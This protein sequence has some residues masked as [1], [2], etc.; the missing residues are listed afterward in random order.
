MNQLNWPTIKNSHVLAQITLFKIAGIQ[1]IVIC[2]CT[3]ARIPESLLISRLNQQPGDKEN[4]TSRNFCLCSYLVSLEAQMLAWAFIYIPTLYVNAV[5]AL[6]RLRICE[7]LPEP[8]LF[9]YVKST[10]FQCIG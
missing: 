2:G 7:G 3:S 8:S 6:A 4:K 1:P 5:E 9:A 10:Q